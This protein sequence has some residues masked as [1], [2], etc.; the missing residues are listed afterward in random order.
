MYNTKILLQSSEV[1]LGKD[2]ID[3]KFNLKL[4]KVDNSHMINENS[5]HRS[6]IDSARES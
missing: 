2:Y 1:E 6:Y 4:S 3:K 5:T